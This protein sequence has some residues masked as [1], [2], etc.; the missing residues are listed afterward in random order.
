MRAFLQKRNE[1]IV[2]IGEDGLTA[3]YLISGIVHKRM[4]SRTIQEEDTKELLEIL[5]KDKTVKL[6]IYLDH[7][8]QEYTQGSIPGVNILS[9]KKIAQKRPMQIQKA[10]DIKYLMK[11]IA[12]LPDVAIGFFCI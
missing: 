2:S 6:N 7:Q 3:V 4:F 8:F 12:R 10:I 1:L 5:Q 11:F 9:A